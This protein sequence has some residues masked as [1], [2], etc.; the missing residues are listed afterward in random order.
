MDNQAAELKPKAEDRAFL[1]KR[2]L[3]LR[4]ADGKLEGPGARRG[5]SARTRDD[6]LWLFRRLRN[7][8][9]E[10]LGQLDAKRHQRKPLKEVRLELL[11]A[12]NAYRK[13]KN[14]DPLELHPA[15][16]AAAQGHAAYLAQPG[17]PF[18][19]AGEAGSS[20][21][22]RIGAEKYYGMGTAENVAHAQASGDA[23]VAAWIKSPGHEA[24]LVDRSMKH[25]GFGYATD[26]SGRNVWVQVFGAPKS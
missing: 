3:D 8:V 6:M 5:L 18:G 17:S 7:A 2:W 9:A 11:A 19:H 21:N 25:V 14:A 13:T 1:M 23:A 4:D 26:T 20:P 10:L 12:S 16:N 22:A 15:L 24:N